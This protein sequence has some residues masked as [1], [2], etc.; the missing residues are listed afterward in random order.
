MIKIVTEGVKAINPYGQDQ[1][2]L[3]FTRKVYF[4]GILVYIHESKFK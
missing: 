4:L 3:N 1:T 2:Q